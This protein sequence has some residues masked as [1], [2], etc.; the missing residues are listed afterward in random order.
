MRN[1]A[2]LWFDNGRL[3]YTLNL[4]TSS[5]SNYNKT[6]VGRDGGIISLPPPPPSTSPSSSSSK[7]SRIRSAFSK[8]ASH[9]YKALL[10]CW[11]LSNS[12]LIPNRPH[13]VMANSQLKANWQAL[14]IVTQILQREEGRRS[15][16]S[17]YGPRL[18]SIHT[19]PL[20][21]P[22]PLFSCWNRWWQGWS[23]PTWIVS[24][25]SLS[26]SLSSPLFSPPPETAHYPLFRKKSHHRYRP[27]SPPLLLYREFVLKS[28]Y[29]EQ[30]YP[31]FKVSTWFQVTIV[32]CFYKNKMLSLALIEITAFFGSRD[33]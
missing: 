14:D 28:I 32:T 11:F 15:S 23:S 33:I 21:H 3:Y 9:T 19:P 1:Q 7:T 12:T 16:L 6:V 22:L 5:S 29:L 27:T 20:F 13:P 17:W 30:W 2:M 25:S 10:L 4:S 8:M 24:S 31:S 26:H 18:S